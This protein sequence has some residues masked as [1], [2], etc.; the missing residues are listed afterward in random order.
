MERFCRGSSVHSTRISI[1]RP[2]LP[3]AD[4]F[5]VLVVGSSGK[6][7]QERTEAILARLTQWASDRGLVFSAEKSVL[8]PLKGGLV[9]GF[10]VSLGTNRIKAVG[11]T[12][13]LGIF[14]DADMKYNSHIENI[15][16]KSMDPFSSLKATVKS[17]CIALMVYKAVYVPRVTYAVGGW[18]QDSELSKKIKDKINSA[19]RRPITG[20][21]KTM[22]TAILQVLAGVMPL[23]VEIGM[24]AAI[25][26]GWS[27]PPRGIN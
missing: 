19:Q 4:D 1:F 15:L 2:R 7:I 16:G 21:Y 8:L 24:C 17:K 11:V 18:Y 5:A 13:Y 20:A 27:P 14:L 9:P 23:D 26:N 6:N 10:T 22:S 25:H 3:Y 12:K